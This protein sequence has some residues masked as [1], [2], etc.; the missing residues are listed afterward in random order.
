MV[1]HY[2]Y[3]AMERYDKN[4]PPITFRVNKALYDRIDMYCIRTKQSKKAV[5]I[6]ALTK[7]L[8]EKEK[9]PEE[10]KK[11]IRGIF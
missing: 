1:K 5:V 2:K 10:P 3:P 6:E 8:D 7:L 4:N 9:P 11:G